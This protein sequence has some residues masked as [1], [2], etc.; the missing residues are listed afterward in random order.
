[1]NLC[2]IIVFWKNL[3]QNSHTTGKQSVH[4]CTPSPPRNTPTNRS[5]KRGWGC[6]FTRLPLEGRLRRR[7]WWGVA[8]KRRSSCKARTIQAAAQHNGNLRCLH[9]IRRLRRHLP[10]KGKAWFSAHLHA[11]RNDIWRTNIRKKLNVNLSAPCE[12]RGTIR[13]DGG[14]VVANDFDRR[15][16]SR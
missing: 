2:K 15:Y 3:R 16:V 9:L 14:G 7:R 8:A 10:L 13:K 4:K 5:L 6:H 12:G 1:M 11:N